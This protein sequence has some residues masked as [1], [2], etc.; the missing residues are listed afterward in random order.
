MPENTN[1]DDANLECANNVP[2]DK[3]V[4][5]HVDINDRLSTSNDATIAKREDS[6]SNFDVWWSVPENEDPANPRNWSNS[7]K[8]TM[9]ASLSFVTF[10]TYAFPWRPSS[11]YYQF[12]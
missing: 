6:T 7:R 11:G 3:G 1:D 10:L 4:D 9:I 12:D 2:L 8:W 5:S